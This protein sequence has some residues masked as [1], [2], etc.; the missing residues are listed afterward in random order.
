[1]ASAFNV[2]VEDLPSDYEAVEVF[3]MVRCIQAD[4]EPTLIMRASGG[5]TPWEAIGMII[6]AEDSVR[7]DMQG[8][9]GT[10]DEDD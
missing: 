3:C 5:V 1:M 8:T 9:L 4:G 10:W 2:P 6:A 7:S